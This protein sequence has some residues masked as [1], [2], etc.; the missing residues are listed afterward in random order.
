[1][2][3][4]CLYIAKCPTEGQLRLVGGNNVREGRVEVCFGETWATICD[5]LW[6]TADANN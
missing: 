1:M 3:Y 5:A 6:S 4:F 2:F